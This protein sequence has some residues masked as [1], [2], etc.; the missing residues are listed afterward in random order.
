MRAIISVSDKSG[1]VEGTQHPFGEGFGFGLVEPVFLLKR[2]GS[3][4]HGKYSSRGV[5]LPSCSNT[6]RLP[7][8]FRR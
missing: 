6:D 2:G 1:I 8:A 7:G 5:T 3:V 4:R